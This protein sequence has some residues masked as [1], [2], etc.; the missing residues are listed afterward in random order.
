M[1][2]KCMTAAHLQDEELIAD[3]HYFH[4]T[5]LQDVDEKAL[6]R[7]ARVAKD[8]RTYDEVARAEDARAGYDLPVQ[9]EPEE[10][11]ALKAEKDVLFSERGM[12]IVILTVSLAA[13]LQGFVQSSI[14]GASL[15]PTVFGLY[16]PD[17][18]NGTQPATK[19]GIQPDDWKLGAANA[20]PFFFAALLGCWLS[21]PINDRIGRRGAMA[22]A[23]CLIFGSSLGAAFCRNWI[24]LFSVRIING[25]GTESLSLSRVFAVC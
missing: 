12:L 3:V 21:L 17:T 5:Y 1:L 6:L 23:G 11:A 18:G 13:F 24:A 9:L 25:I 15:Y 4:Q 22:V 8:A 10:K 16:I 2:I 20:S 19:T 14:N 7:A